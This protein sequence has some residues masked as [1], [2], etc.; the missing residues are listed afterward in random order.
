MLFVVSLKSYSKQDV[1]FPSM[2]IERGLKPLN[3]NK[4]GT[5]TLFT[6]SRNLIFYYP[7]V[8]CKTQHQE[9]L[10]EK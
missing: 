1:T 10:Q 6:N 7:H 8:L 3:G 4:H 9:G 5:R 2:T